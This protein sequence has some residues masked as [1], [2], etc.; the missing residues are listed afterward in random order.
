[1]P[2]TMPLPSRFLSTAALASAMAALLLS[3]QLGHTTG[4]RTTPVAA[5]SPEMMQVLRDEHGLVATMLEARLA[6]EKQQLTTARGPAG[7]AAA[8]PRTIAR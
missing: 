5:A 7:T 4:P 2:Q 3:Y 1:M 6:T 8:A